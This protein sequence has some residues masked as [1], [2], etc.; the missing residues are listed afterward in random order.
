MKS[1]TKIGALPLLSP[2][3]GKP[4]YGLIIKPRFDWSGIGPMLAVMGWRVIPSPLKLPL[5]PRSE[6]KIP[7]WVLSTMILIRLKAL[8]DRLERR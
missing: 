4:D 2:T 5:L 8:L 7:P 6:R 1:G 3:S